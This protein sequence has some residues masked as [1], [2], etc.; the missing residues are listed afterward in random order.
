MNAL[1]EKSVDCPYC[2]ERIELLLDPSAGE[3]QEYVEDCAVCC[4]PM[5]VSFTVANGLVRRLT[6][7]AG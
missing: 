3:T 5:T 6:V 7:G 4:Q 2:G 1:I